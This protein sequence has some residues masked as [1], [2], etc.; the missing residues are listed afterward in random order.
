MRHLSALL[1]L[2]SILPVAAAAPVGHYLGELP[3]PDGRVLKIGV[4]LFKRADGASWASFASPDQ[5]AYD[6]PVQRY[7]ENGKALELDLGWATIALTEQKSGLAGSYTQNGERSA[8]VLKKVDRFPQRSRPQSP[9]GPFPYSSETLA[10]KGGEGVML[11]ATLTLP[12]GKRRPNLVLLV[13]GSGPTNRD[14]MVAGH[15][16]LK[17]LADYLSRRGLAVLRY[18]KRGIA[19]SSGNFDQHTFGQLVDDL[20]G[21]VSAMRARGQFG[22][23]GAAGIS[24]GPGV[25]A[26]LEMRTPGVLDFLVSLSGVGLNGMDMILLQ[27]RVYLERQKPGSEELARLMEYVATWYQTIGAH[28]AP[29]ARVAALKAL[30]ASLTPADRALITQYKADHGTLSMDWASKPFVHAMLQTDAPAQWRSVRCPVLALGGSLD[31]QVPASENVGAIVA[32]LRAGGNGAVEW[33]ILPSLNHLL[34][35]AVTGAEDEYERID[36]TL[37]PAVMATIARFASSPTVSPQLDG[38]L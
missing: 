14:G 20:G 8:I 9:R 17:V 29:Q 21:V 38:K 24:E 35:T 28:E 26:A 15:E 31:V 13:N 7:T 22:R 25:A 12:H 16:Q 32:A 6:I 30:T 3:V 34:Q 33:H 23:I 18:D 19:R 10:I 1:F 2:L 36:E 37:A 5:G 27:D 11:G 4:E